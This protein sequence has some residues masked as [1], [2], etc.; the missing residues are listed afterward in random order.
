M[1][2]P[3]YLHL[4]DLEPLLSE[5]AGLQLSAEAAD[6]VSR[7]FQFLQ[8]YMDRAERPVYGVNTGFGSLC[9]VQISS[10]NLEELQ[11]NLL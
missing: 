10:D 1:I 8:S 9:D 11:R 4:E 6:A 5:H 2:L 7:S 3:H